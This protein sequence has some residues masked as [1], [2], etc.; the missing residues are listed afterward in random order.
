M[1]NKSYITIKS[2]EY[3]DFCD[4]SAQK[5]ILPIQKISLDKSKIFFY[6]S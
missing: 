2:D 5:L 3:F 1:L 6:K 4:G